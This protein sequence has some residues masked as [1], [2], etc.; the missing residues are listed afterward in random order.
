MKKTGAMKGGMG[1]GKQKERHRKIVI[2]ENGRIY[3]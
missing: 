2:S 3:Q 1:E